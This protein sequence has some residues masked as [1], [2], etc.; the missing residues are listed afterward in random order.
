M[1]MAAR[2]PYKSKNGLFAMKVIKHD[3]ITRHTFKGVQVILDNGIAAVD[4]S[5]CLP[6]GVTKSS[7]SQGHP[8]S[9][10]TKITTKLLL[11][12]IETL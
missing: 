7:S 10:N 6:D 4:I 1:Q 2:K 3:I 9:F 12:N 8:E 5:F 11:P